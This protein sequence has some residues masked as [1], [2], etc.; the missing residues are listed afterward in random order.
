MRNQPLLSHTV[1]KS[2]REKVITKT[3]WNNRKYFYTPYISIPRMPT[4]P[5][6]KKMVLTMD[7]LS[8]G[9]HPFN[10][11]KCAKRVKE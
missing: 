3:N 9:S 10:G 6:K 8:G 4:A 11:P 2:N 1:T 7:K 5:K